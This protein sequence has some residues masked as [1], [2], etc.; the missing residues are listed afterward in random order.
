MTVPSKQS[1]Y[2]YLC[3]CG[4]C[5]I[6][7]HCCVSRK[8]VVPVKEEDICEVAVVSHTQAM[9]ESVLSEIAEQQVQVEVVPA[10]VSTHTG[11]P[12]GRPRK[13]HTLPNARIDA[14]V[15]TALL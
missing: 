5:M 13:I 2:L 9:G 6:C 4:T 10:P 12:R 14:E 7:R 11:K 1:M 3:A 8:V 15:C